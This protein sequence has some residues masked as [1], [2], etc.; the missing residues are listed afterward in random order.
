MSGAPVQPEPA[1]ALR[2]A[3]ISRAFTT[4]RRRLLRSPGGNPVPGQQRVALP[5]PLGFCTVSVG[6]V[7]GLLQPVGTAVAG[8]VLFE[9]KPRGT[10][11]ARVEQI[12]VE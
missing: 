2:G 3:E 7:T 9:R 4:G 10:R 6:R 11:H 12:P 5:R 8:L 1:I